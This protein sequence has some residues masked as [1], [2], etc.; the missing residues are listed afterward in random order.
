LRDID[1]KVRQHYL[2]R[3][4]SV[5][6]LSNIIGDI[7]RLMEQAQSEAE[8]A[9][10]RQRDPATEATGRALDGKITAKMGA[11]GRVQELV[12]ADEAMNLS[13]KELAR[14]IVSALNQA[15]AARQSKD[16]AAAAAMA[17]DPAALAARM[18][19]LRQE[20]VQSMQRITDSLADVMQKIDRKLS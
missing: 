14:E 16:P 10:D 17:V 20:S 2:P 12:L 3:E 6:D 13:S 11:D 7:D 8:K 18:R 15:W 1:L 9:R 4:E 19:E 5:S